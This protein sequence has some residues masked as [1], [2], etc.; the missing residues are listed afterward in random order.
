MKRTNK[1]AA[2]KAQFAAL[3]RD[4]HKALL[5]HFAQCPELFAPM[6]DLI[7]NGQAGDRIG[8]EPG[9]ACGG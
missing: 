2:S 4:D 7:A 8:D 6:L 3:Q 5:A 9:G 1:N